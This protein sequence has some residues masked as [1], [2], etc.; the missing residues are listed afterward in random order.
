MDATQPAPRPRKPL[1]KVLSG[2]TWAPWS[3][4]QAPA[5]LRALP[6]LRASEQ[7]GVIDG[8]T[9]RLV[10]LHSVH[11]DARKRA[12]FTP[13]LAKRR[14]ALHKELST[15]ATRRLCCAA[16]AVEAAGALLLR[17]SATG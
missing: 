16:D 2:A 3:S 15:L 9:Y 11:L 6:G 4:R 1:G 17:T 12:T 13:T 7:S 8:R 14:D 10:V 5:P